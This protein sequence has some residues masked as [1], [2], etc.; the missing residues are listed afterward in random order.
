MELN[1]LQQHAYNTMKE[2]KSLFLNGG[3]GVGKSHVIGMYR[4]F[5]TIKYPSGVFVTALLIGGQT[6][7]KYSGIRTGEG[8]VDELLKFIMFSTKAKD[9][10]NRVN[11]LFIDE[12]SM[13]L[14]DM[15]DKLEKIARIMKKNSLPFGGIQVI[16]SGDFFQ[17]PPVRKDKIE[18]YC[19]EAETWNQVITET[20]TLTEI[21]RQKNPVFQNLLK[22]ARYGSIND[23]DADLLQS[24]V[25]VKLENESGIEPTRFYSK[26]DDV[27]LHNNKRLRMLL[28]TE[29]EY[30]YVAT[31]QVDYSG[32]LSRAE[33]IKQIEVDAEK[34]LP[35][36][37]ILA[38]GAQVIFKKNINEMVANG[39]RGVIVGFKQLD[40][41]K[42]DSPM[43]PVVKLLNGCEHHAVPEHFEY[44]CK[45][46]YKLKRIQVPIKLAYATS[47]HSSQGSTVEYAEI[48]LG[49]SVFANGQAYVALSRV[50]NIDGLTLIHFNRDSI[51]A[52][53]KVVDMFPNK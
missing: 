16:C 17:L 31:H 6:V 7:H 41:L 52:S 1:V 20:I 10:W 53:Q 27:N 23:E 35:A 39:T 28:E 33:L 37:N 12:I 3:A 26:L 40:V 24:R 36:I 19:F 46:V 43:Y 48:D 34:I 22:R 15:F 4:D 25:G 42:P 30:K 44:E 47:I 51:K 21:M 32:S 38:K 11:V 18:S 49:T 9:N 5:A 45:D 13:I 2:G 29:P 8:T 50:T 14:P